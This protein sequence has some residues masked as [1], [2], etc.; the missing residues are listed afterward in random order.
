M[1]K[2]INSQLFEWDDEKAKVNE[3]KHGISFST[4]A[5]VFSDENRIERL[6]M[7]H[8]DDEERWQVIGE[9]GSVLFVVYTDRGEAT[10]LISARKATARERSI[11][12]AS[13]E[14]D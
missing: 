5:R 2:R 8:S 6:D 7:N 12:Y 13:Q 3:I 14:M 11:Y 1:R 9:V 10:R 4:A